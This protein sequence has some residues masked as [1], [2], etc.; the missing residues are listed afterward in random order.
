MATD[1]EVNNIIKW[2]RGLDQTGMRSR[3]VG[4]DL[5]HDGVAESSVTWRL[6]DVIH[7]TP[8]AVSRPN[9]GYH[10][11]YRDNTYAAFVN[12]YQNRRHVIY[13]GGNDGMLHAVNG[14]FYDAPNHRFCRSEDCM[15]ETLAPELGAELW[16]YVP[17]NLL[18]YLK[19]LTDPDYLH[20]YFVDSSPRIFD[21]QIFN[22]DSVH[23]YG[24]GTILVVG[25]RFGGSKTC[26]PPQRCRVGKNTMRS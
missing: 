18:P 14:G 20:Q 4:V 16:A 2:I 13:F 22:P 10:F 25:M 23:P 19:C 17:Y 11:L 24:W 7:S 12:Q 26:A 6:G 9:E 8:T 1:A 15:L 5:N 21:V 3:Q